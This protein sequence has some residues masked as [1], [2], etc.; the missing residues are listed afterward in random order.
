MNMD[1]QVALWQEMESFRC[2]PRLFNSQKWDIFLHLFLIQDHYR[3]VEMCSLLYI[4]TLSN[5]F[6][7]KMFIK[8]KSFE[9]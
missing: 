7:K 2:V 4:D 9:V 8:S 6:A 1:E 5:Y 3:Y